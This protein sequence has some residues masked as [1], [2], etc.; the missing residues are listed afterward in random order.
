MIRLNPAIA[1][2]DPALLLYQDAIATQWQSAPLIGDAPFAGVDSVT[3]RLLVDVLAPL[4]CAEQESVLQVATLLPRFLQAGKP[5]PELFLAAMMLDEAR[6]V[7]VLWR[8]L[9]AASPAGEGDEELLWQ[10]Q[11]LPLPEE[12]VQAAAQLAAEAMGRGVC[13]DLLARRFENTALQDVLTK[14][15]AE[16]RRH[17]A[18]GVSGWGDGGAALRQRLKQKPA[19]D[20]VPGPLEAWEKLGITVRQRRESEARLLDE[21]HMLPAAIH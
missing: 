1:D 19:C 11:P 17:A 18:F 9:S 21:L 6:H 3:Q 2:D 5:T 13:Y 10:A 16:E 8:L 14:L 15:G 12:E 4:L 20:R 7:E